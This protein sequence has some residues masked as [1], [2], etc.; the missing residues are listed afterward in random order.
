MSNRSKGSDLWCEILQVSVT[1]ETKNQIIQI[2]RETNT[3]Q[4]NVVREL[5]N[6]ALGKEPFATD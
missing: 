1:I 6:Q 4:S 3:S 5:L 2:A